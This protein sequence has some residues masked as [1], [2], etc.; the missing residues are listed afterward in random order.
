M[1]YM[2]DKNDKKWICD[3]IDEKLDVRFAEQNKRL[4][5]VMDARFADMIET[6]DKRFDERFD[7]AEHSFRLII[8]NELKPMLAA[9]AEVLPGAY[10]SYSNLEDGVS[11]IEREQDIL[12][13][14]LVERM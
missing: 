13:N 3:T 2:L 9:H 6:L 10:R 5:E 14:A 8:E 11:K 7:R 4:N 12:K 1:S